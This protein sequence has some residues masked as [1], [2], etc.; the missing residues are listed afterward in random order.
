MFKRHEYWILKGRTP[1]PVSMLTWA[2]WFNDSAQRIVAQ[3][4]V[5]RPDADP[6]LVSTVFLGLDHNYY[7]SGPPI[8]FETM[9]FGGPLDGYQYR[10]ATFEE[11]LQGHQLCTDETTLEGKVAA[12][13]VAARIK[14]IAD[15]SKAVH[16]ELAAIRR[17]AAAS[18]G[19]R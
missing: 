1:V 17:A 9:V 10:Y 7:P 15:K 4:E 19:A 16:A 5:R 18:V 11:A 12:W 6:V 14:G 13:E 2:R 3:T 8:L